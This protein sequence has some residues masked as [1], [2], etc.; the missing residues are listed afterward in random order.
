VTET[1]D[2]P[3]C[4]HCGRPV[5]GRA[6]VGGIDVCH[7]GT[8]P[9]QADPPDCY[10]PVTVYREPLG[11]RIGAELAEAPDDD[12]AH[13]LVMNRLSEV[14]LLTG[15]Q[16]RRVARDVLHTLAADGFVLARRQPASPQEGASR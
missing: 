13:R 15:E 8:M 9:P 11:A 16:C 12:R 1:N 14:T 7:A 5:T 3:L 2:R 4:G 10:R 6:S